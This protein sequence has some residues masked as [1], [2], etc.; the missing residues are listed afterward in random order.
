MAAVTQA[1]LPNKMRA[2]SRRCVFPADLQNVLVLRGVSSS[3]R[4]TSSVARAG[5]DRERAA[6]ASGRRSRAG[7]DRE[8]ANEER[9]NLTVK[10]LDFGRINRCYNFGK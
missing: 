7:G 9:R 1:I 10:F 2:T 3:E 4:V 5:G 8:R 6:I